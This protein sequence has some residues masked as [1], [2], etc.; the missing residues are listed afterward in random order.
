MWEECHQDVFGRIREELATAPVL[1]YADYIRP[2]RIHTD[3]SSS[4]Q[5][6]V[7]CKHY[8]GEDRVV[9]YAS[10]SLKPSESGTNQVNWKWAI[11]VKFHDYLYGIPF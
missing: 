6:A 8:N 4:G 11:T 5:G 9:A 1:A 7:L 2:S 3:A 10:R